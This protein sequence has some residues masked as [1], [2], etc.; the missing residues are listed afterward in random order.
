M[1]VVAIENLKVN[2]QVVTDVFAKRGQELD[3]DDALNLLHQ[4][5]NEVD[6][7]IKSRK[8]L[9]YLLGSHVMRLDRLAAAHGEGV[10]ADRAIAVWKKL[11]NDGRQVRR[12]LRAIASSP[13]CSAMAAFTNCRHHQ[14]ATA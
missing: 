2:H 4:R 6:D 10:L 13:C 11:A 14:S 1:C 12:Q 8:L 3:L 9:W 5:S 7:P